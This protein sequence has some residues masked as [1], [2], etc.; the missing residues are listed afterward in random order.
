MNRLA[1]GFAA[2]WVFAAMTA[3]HGTP[4]TG[5][6]AKDWV[7]LADFLPGAGIA[8]DVTDLAYGPQERQKLDFWKPRNASGGPA[9]LV[10]FIHGGGFVTGDKSEARRLPMTLDCVQAGMAF[11]AINYR[12][13]VNGNRLPDSLRDAA[14]AVQFLRSQSASLGFDP[15]RVAAF[16]QSAG[17]GASLW[18][19][20][21]ADM[22]D[23]AST[24]PVCRQSTRLVAAGAIDGQATY[25]PADVGPVLGLDPKGDGATPPWL[26]EQAFGLKDGE[27]TAARALF[28]GV[29]PIRHVT[30]DDPPVFLYATG[31]QGVVMPKVANA[32]GG[33]APGFFS[34]MQNAVEIPVLHNPAHARALGRAMEKA[35]VECLVRT[36]ANYRDTPPF[37]PPRCA[38]RVE[39]WRFL[40]REFGMNPD[41]AI[42]ELA[43]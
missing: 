38:A 16:G 13:T 20:F 41:T 27:T 23:R 24:D 10:V 43:K 35:G 5:A 4:P 31:A 11:A 29:S 21:H 1:A 40:R 17:G 19:A 2:A 15:N 6:G 18:L 12:L 9:P 7:Q 14:R 32:P 34:L 3:A 25:D 22:A 28:A 42:P 36:P 39:M 30:P 37:T 33:G 8:P 26:L